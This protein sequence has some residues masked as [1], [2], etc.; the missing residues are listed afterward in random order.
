MGIYGRTI[1]TADPF[2]GETE[3][4]EVILRQW[5]AHTLQT[6]PGTLRTRPEH[7]VDLPGM[8]LASLTPT[9]RVAIPAM[10]KTSLE[11]GRRVSTASV[12]LV[13]TPLGGGRVALSLDIEVTPANGGP[14]VT[15]T[16]QVD[17][18]L[19]DYMITGA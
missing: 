16:H 2:F 15:Y 17:D 3:D 4:D 13:E 19:A 14:G 6:R 9:E 8:L 7:G 18:S 12:T 10:V 11:A 5:I 1:N